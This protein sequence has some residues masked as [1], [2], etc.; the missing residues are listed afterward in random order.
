MLSARGSK[1]L[2]KHFRVNDINGRLNE[3]NND[4]VKSYRRDVGNI[5]EVFFQLRVCVLINTGA[6]TP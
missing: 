1:H 5:L 2:N 6:E 3:M 4:F